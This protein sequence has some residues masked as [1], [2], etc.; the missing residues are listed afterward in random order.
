MTQHQLISHDFQFHIHTHNFYLTYFSMH[1]ERLSDKES[2]RK[3]II[4]GDD[5]KLFVRCANNSVM[6]KY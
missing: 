1:T 2:N 3:G 4:D 6:Y 5:D